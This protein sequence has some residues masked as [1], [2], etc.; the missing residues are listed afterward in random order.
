VNIS[1]CGSVKIIRRTTGAFLEGARFVLCK[2]NA[3]LGG[4]RG[5]EDTLTSYSC[6][7]AS[8]HV[9]DDNVLMGSYWAVESI[10]PP[11]HDAA[12][13]QSVTVGEHAGRATFID[14]RHRGAIKITKT[15]KHAALGAGDHPHAGVDFTVGGHK[16]TGETALSASMASCSHTVTRPSPPATRAKPTRK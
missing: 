8:T 3:P 12:A 9:R 6:D 4:S 14:L 11:N 1:N 16:A 5:A 13:D 7:T 15:R 2:D 10:V